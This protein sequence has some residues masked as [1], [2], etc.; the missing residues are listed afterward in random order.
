MFLKLL[1]ISIFFMVLVFAGLGIR[2]LLKPGG[3]FP[4]THISHNPE[5]KKRGITCAQKTDLGCTPS[6]ENSGCC[7]CSIRD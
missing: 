7:S 1:I 2:M 6:D 3:R 5:M 4:E